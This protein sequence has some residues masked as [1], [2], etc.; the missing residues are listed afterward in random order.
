MSFNPFVLDFCLVFSSVS[1]VFRFLGVR[2]V[3]LMMMMMNLIAWGC[4]FG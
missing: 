4:C 3:L 2:M 1:C